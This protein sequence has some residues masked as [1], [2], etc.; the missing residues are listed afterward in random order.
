MST[1]SY[2]QYCSNNYSCATFKVF[3]ILSAARFIALLVTGEHN[4]AINIA[5]PP[6]YSLQPRRDKPFCGEKS[7]RDVADN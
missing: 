4:L 6:T 1:G 3:I 5:Q 7:N 2:P